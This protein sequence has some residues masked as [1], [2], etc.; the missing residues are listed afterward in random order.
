[1]ASYYNP[2][3]SEEPRNQPIKVFPPMAQE[4]FIGWLESTSRFLNTDNNEFQEHKVSE[5][6][7]DILDSDVYN[8][9]NSDNS[10]NEEE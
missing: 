3:L 2:S 7:D 4:T 9:D 1:M 10:D 5:D 8:S 6:I